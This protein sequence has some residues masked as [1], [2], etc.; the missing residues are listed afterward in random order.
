MNRT[1]YKSIKPQN[2]LII[3]EHVIQGLYVIMGKTLLALVHP[4]TPI[5]RNIVAC[6]YRLQLVFINKQICD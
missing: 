1:N 3:H 4:S 6:D 5:S 2:D